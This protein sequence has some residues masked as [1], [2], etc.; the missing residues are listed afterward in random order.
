MHACMLGSQP[1]HT[2]ST[3]TA[4]GSQQQQSARRQG[5][6]AKRTQLPCGRHAAPAAHLP[7]VYVQ[8]ELPH[9][10]GYM[11]QRFWDPPADPSEGAGGWYTACI[12]DF[13]P[14]SNEYV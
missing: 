3:C 7:Y 8:G 11:V 10:I 9:Y 14:A 1:L 5:R 13:D 6:P 12:T 2:R 4:S